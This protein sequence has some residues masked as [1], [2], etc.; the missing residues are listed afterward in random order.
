MTYCTT[1]TYALKREFESLIIKFSRMLSMPNQK[2]AADITYG[3]LAA[4]CCLLTD[5]VDQFHENSKKVNSVE[6]LTRHLNKG[7]PAKALKSYLAPVR[8]WTPDES[9]IHSDGGDIVKPNR[10]RFES[11]GLVK[12]RSKSTKN[13]MSIK[14]AKHIHNRVVNIIITVLGFPHRNRTGSFA[15]PNIPAK[16]L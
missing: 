5:V 8:K 11:L 15:S 1:N 6:H 16:K 12:D 4:G 10:H 9:I 7:F 3:L 13:K 2:Y 14:K